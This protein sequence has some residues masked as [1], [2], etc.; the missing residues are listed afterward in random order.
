M[1][2]INAILAHDL[3]KRQEDAKIQKKLENEQ[4]E[5]NGWEECDKAIIHSKE[6]PQTEIMQ[7][8]ME[9][10]LAEAREE[11]GDLEILIVMLSRNKKKLQEKLANHHIENEDGQKQIKH[12]L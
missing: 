11:K 2:Q 9:K 6:L 4:L 8:S 10:Q 1:I 5:V 12:I 7:Q 3:N